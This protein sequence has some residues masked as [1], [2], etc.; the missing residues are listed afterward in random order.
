MQPLAVVHR[1]VGGRIVTCSCYNNNFVEFAQITIKIPC[2]SYLN[3]RGWKYSL[4]NISTP[5]ASAPETKT[6]RL[7]FATFGYQTVRLLPPKNN[8]FFYLSTDLLGGLWQWFQRDCSVFFRQILATNNYVL[9]SSGNNSAGSVA[10]IARI[11]FLIEQVWL[12]MRHKTR[13]PWKV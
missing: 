11:V 9:S 10:R 13:S 12:A 7:Y 5:N 4:N 1:S 8:Y 2:L 6:S 3:K